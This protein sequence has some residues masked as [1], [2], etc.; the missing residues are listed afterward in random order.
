MDS[1]WEFVSPSKTM[2]IP[3]TAIGTALWYLRS[4]LRSELRDTRTIAANP[5]K[6]GTMTRTPTTVLE[7]PL[8]S[9]LTTCGM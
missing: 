2:A 4:N 3:A 8:E 1:V 9:A 6:W 7:K 5:A